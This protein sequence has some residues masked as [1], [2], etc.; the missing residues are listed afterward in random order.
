MRKV[1]P[2]QVVAGH[3][4]YDVLALL[5]KEIEVRLGSQPSDA[6]VGVMIEAIEF[7]LDPVRT[8]RTSIADLDNV[9]KTFV[10]L[11][12]EHYIRDLLDAPKGIRDLILAGRDV[13][14]KNTVSNS[15]SWM[16]P[17]ETYRGAEP[18]IL[19]SADEKERKSWMGLMLSRDE[20]LG[21]PNR[22]KKRGILSGAYQ[23]IFWLAAGADWPKSRW[24]GLDMK[25]FRDLRKI[26]IGKNRAAQFFMENERRV[27][28]RSVLLALLHDQKDPMKRLRINGGAPDILIKKNVA[29]LS[30]RYN[31]ALAKKLGFDLANDEW[32]AV[33]PKTTNEISILRDAGELK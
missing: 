11:K 19:L 1:P 6:F 23:N 9:E 28:H 20:Y 31:G 29:L 18:V 8:G 12:I 10:G 14:I 17:P 25:R 16:V 26:K 13:D 4:D 22:D 30:G 15:W 24:E 7:V 21:A 27:T 3:P 2:S 33:S 5:A 32:V